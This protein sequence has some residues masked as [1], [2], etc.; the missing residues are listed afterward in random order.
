MLE[1][2]YE[3]EYLGTV[4]IRIR[5]VLSKKGIIAGSYVTDGKVTRNAHCRVRR[6]RDLVYEGK[7]STLKHL[8]DDVREVTTGMECGL[9]FE[10]WE[11]F[12]EGDVVEAY[13]MIQVNA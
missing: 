10:N 8:R 11:D 13:E 2:K 12:K 6:D 1:P 4:D 7:I 5:F 3:E 9:T